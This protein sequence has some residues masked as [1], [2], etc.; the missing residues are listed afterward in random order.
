MTIDFFKYVGRRHDRLGSLQPKFLCLLSGA[1]E[2]TPL[3]G[4]KGPPKFPDRRNCLEVI[5][6][7]GR[8]SEVSHIADRI[9][10]LRGVKHGKLVLTTQGKGL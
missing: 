8:S 6:M 1:Q 4:Q 9:L 7:W 10:S 3:R 5:M 2:Y